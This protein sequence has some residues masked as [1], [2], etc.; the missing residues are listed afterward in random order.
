[1]KTRPKKAHINFYILLVLI[2]LIIS[3]AI[4]I[5][6]SNK[7]TAS[8]IFYKVNDS[9]YT[10]KH[11]SQ[12][13]G[14]IANNIIKDLIA[15]KT[16]FPELK[17]ISQNGD[18]NL[19]KGVEVFGVTFQYNDAETGKIEWSVD[20]SKYKKPELPE[21]KTPLSLDMLPDYAFIGK[22]GEMLV[23]LDF[24]TDNN[25]LKNEIISILKKNGAVEQDKRILWA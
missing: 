16:K 25:K 2:L 17:G 22:I 3:G 6:T 18:Y 15:L 10:E 11:N 8:K 4:M 7:Q 12:T 19:V 9:F 23:V 14:E 13:Y 20:I 21:G 24:N 1:M 5:E